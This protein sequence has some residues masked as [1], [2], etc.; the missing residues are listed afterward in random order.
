MRVLLDTH[1]V[2]WVS[3]EPSRLPRSVV[4]L[5]ESEGVE[6]WFSVARLWEVSIKTSLG[7]AG[8]RV[9]PHQL[10][11][12]LLDNGYRELTITSDH[13]I[14]VAKLPRIH[15]DPFDRLLVAQAS[16]EGLELITTDHALARYGDPVRYFG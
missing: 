7:R 2:L 9:D 11:L 12:S 4:E 13:A 1:F 16:L 8:F 15:G 10:R 5:L 6:P 3:L 14:A